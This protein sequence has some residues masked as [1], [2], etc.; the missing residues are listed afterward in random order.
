M[1]IRNLVVLNS[2]STLILQVRN[3]IHFLIMYL[4]E[5]ICSVQIVTKSRKEGRSCVGY[6]D[7]RHL[8]IPAFPFLRGCPLMESHIRALHPY[9]ILARQLLSLESSYIVVEAQVV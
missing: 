9:Y 3:Y 5:I 8:R 1:I 2:C 7:I 6:V 4:F